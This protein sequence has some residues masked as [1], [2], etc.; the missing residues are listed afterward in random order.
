MNMAVMWLSHSPGDS[1]CLENFVPFGD[2]LLDS[3]P[4]STVAQW[5]GRVFYIAP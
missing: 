5:V 3:R 1:D 4:F 2:S